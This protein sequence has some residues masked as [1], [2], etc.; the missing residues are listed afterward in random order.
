MTSY[1][2]QISTNTLR[3]HCALGARFS[4]NTLKGE[5][6]SRCC[7]F[8]FI[9]LDRTH[10]LLTH[11]PPLNVD[12]ETVNSSLQRST[13][14]FGH[15][16]E[17]KYGRS[18]KKVTQIKSWIWIFYFRRF[19][20]RSRMETRTQTVCLGEWFRGHCRF[21]IKGAVTDGPWEGCSWLSGVIDR[22]KGSENEMDD[23]ETR[24][25]LPHHRRRRLSCDFNGTTKSKP[26]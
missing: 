7:R 3:Y 11:H 22:N 12:F 19:W 17:P 4:P 14:E 18:K 23:S 20:R 26:R 1:Q 21:R 15:Q 6:V 10:G 2:L 24:T 16:G 13:G 8:P 5:I 25:N 9:L